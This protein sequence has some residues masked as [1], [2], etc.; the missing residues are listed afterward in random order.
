MKIVSGLS[1]AAVEAAIEANGSSRYP[2]E[3]SANDFE[4]FV[5][6]LANAGRG[7]VE[8]PDSEFAEDLFSAVA[9][10]L[11]IHTV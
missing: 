5:R 4:R 11:D 7:Y 3:L 1:D 8:E 9:Y 10:T 2:I 6:L